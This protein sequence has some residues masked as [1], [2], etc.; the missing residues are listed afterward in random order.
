MP[1]WA[2]SRECV[3]RAWGAVAP[4]LYEVGCRVRRDM[5]RPLSDVALLLCAVAVGPS[6]ELLLKYKKKQSINRMKG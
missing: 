6:A 4:L 2:V 3:Q 1:R 5:G